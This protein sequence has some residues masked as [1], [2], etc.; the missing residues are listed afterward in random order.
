MGLLPCGTEIECDSNCSFGDTC[1]EGHCFRC[2]EE[3]EEHQGWECGT[4]T[5]VCEDFEGREFEKVVKVGEGCEEPF[6]CGENHTC[7]CDAKTAGSY[8]A[9]GFQCGNMTDMCG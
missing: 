5:V 1:V 2:P 7:F 4:R 9:V 3:A 8:I 6:K